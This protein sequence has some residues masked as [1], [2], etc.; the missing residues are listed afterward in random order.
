MITK[1]L[2]HALNAARRITPRRGAAVLA[3]AAIAAGLT[4]LAAA[5]AHASPVTDSL[6]LPPEIS[7]QIDKLQD[8]PT[9]GS[10]DLSS[11]LDL[12]PGLGQGKD[13]PLP[14]NA[15]T[16][17][18][19]VVH[20]GDSTWTGADDV[21]KV[22][23]ADDTLTTQYKRVGATAEIKHAGNTLSDIATAV[24]QEQSNAKD[25]CFVIA[26]GTK[27]A[28]TGAN[29]ASGIE[30]V[31]TAAG[32]HAVLW[33]TVA[34]AD[35]TT[36]TGYTDSNMRSFNDAPKA[37][38]VKHSNLRIADLAAKTDDTW[39]SADGVDLNA[40]GL[41]DRNRSLADG[42]ATAFPK[43]TSL[44]G[45]DDTTATTPDTDKSKQDEKKTETKPTTPKTTTPATPNILPPEVQKLLPGGQT[46]PK[47]PATPTPTTPATPAPSATQE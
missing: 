41:A 44:P 32:D 34:V 43:G 7:E 31:L 24:K 29:A 40:T 12:V 3:G 10:S 26:A 15:K 2:T 11:L 37:A 42:L 47:T 30:S 35:K 38:A 16:Q 8:L 21:A 46:T 19:S 14:A 4:G 27:T 45:E 36:L 6:N 9:N 20:F 25:T 33:P 18:A 39:F 5:P 1:K 13:S 23:A 22:T 17:C 28:S